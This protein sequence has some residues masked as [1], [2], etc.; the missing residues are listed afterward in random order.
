MKKNLKRTLAFISS[1][2]MLASACTFNVLS[3]SAENRLRL[4][5]I[6]KTYG[7]NDYKLDFGTYKSGDVN[8]DGKIDVTDLDLLM[9]YV[10]GEP[11]S[12]EYGDELADLNQDGDI[13]NLDV[14]LLERYL[15][16]GDDSFIRDVEM[17]KHGKEAYPIYITKDGFGDVDGDGQF[18]A[19]DIY[20]MVNA[21]C[22]E[23]VLSEEQTENS[24]FNQNGTLDIDDIISAYKFNNKIS[25]TDEFNYEIKEMDTEPKDKD[26]TIRTGE[27]QTLLGDMNNDGRFDFDDVDRLIKYIDGQI[28]FSRFYIIKSDVNQDGV[29]DYNDAVDLLAVVDRFKEPEYVTYETRCTPEE[30]EKYYKNKETSEEATLDNVDLDSTESTTESTQPSESS[31]EMSEETAV[32]GLKLGDVNLDGD[33]TIADAVVLN[34]YLVGSATLSESA[35]KNADC[36]KDGNITSS[37]TLTILKYVIGSIDEIK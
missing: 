9:K 21:Y 19:D 30:Y 26:R 12:G 37:D 18:S 3:A 13:N 24:D 27:Y 36:D 22:G 33:V 35:Q 2:S 6:E 8:M 31:N 4:P 29:I 7:Y 16:N 23:T 14:Y 1:L 25:S 34:K 32:E 15:D 20:W 11:I 5:E 10:D 28:K 17:I